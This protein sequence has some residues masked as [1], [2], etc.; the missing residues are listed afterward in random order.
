MKLAPQLSRHFPPEPPA[1]TCLFRPALAPNGKILPRLPGCRQEAG[2][3]PT[4]PCTPWHSTIF[5]LSLLGSFL[6]SRWLGDFLLATSS[7]TSALKPVTT[8]T[9]NTSPFHK[10]LPP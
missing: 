10:I 3:V 7:R 2:P 8:S 6:R 4:E 1:P 9:S 5:S